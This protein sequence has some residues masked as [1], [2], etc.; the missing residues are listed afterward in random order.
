M[1]ASRESLAKYCAE[2]AEQKLLLLRRELM[3]PILTVQ[4][5]ARL[6]QQY[7]AGLT[8][9][10]PEEIRAEDLNNMIDWLAQAATDLEE[11]LLVLTSDCENLPPHHLN[12]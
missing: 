2:P 4:A 11:I 1:S 8:E 7:R 6:F 5:A 9:V 10:L 3:T 12:N